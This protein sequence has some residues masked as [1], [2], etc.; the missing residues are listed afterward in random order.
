[1]RK[2]TGNHILTILLIFSFILT[3]PVQVH[4][5]EKTKQPAKEN[6]MLTEENIRLLSALIFCEAGSEPYAGKV[7][8]GIVIVN[9]MNSKEFPDSLEKVVY[10]KGQFTPAR[11]GALSKVLKKYDKGS[12]NEQNHLDS[13]QAAVE[14]LEG[15]DS[16]TLKGKNVN[17]NSYLFFSTHMKNCRL[18]IGNHKF[19]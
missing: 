8:V 4:A 7:A 5:A 10:Q 15:R 19:K 17:M 3:A 2:T 6:T 18:K 12:F 9:R 14:V 13:V 1:M 16:V 11:S